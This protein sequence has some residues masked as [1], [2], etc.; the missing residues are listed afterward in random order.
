MMCRLVS[1]IRVAINSLAKQALNWGAKEDHNGTLKTIFTR[2]LERWQLFAGKTLAASTYAVVAILLWITLAAL[3][4]RSANAPASLFESLPFRSS[5]ACRACVLDSRRGQLI[6]ASGWSKTCAN[7]NCRL[8][9]TA[10]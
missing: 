9:F 8:R 2:S 5:R 4:K 1:M 3:R 10:M 6:A 7:G